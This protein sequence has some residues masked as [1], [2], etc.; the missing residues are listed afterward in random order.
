[1][2]KVTDLGFWMDSYIKA[3]LDSLCYNILDDWDGVVIVS[4][5]GMV[6]IGKSMLT[7][8]MAYYCLWKLHHNKLNWL[9]IKKQYIDCETTI[10]SGTELI[11]KG[12]S[13]MKNSVFKY[14]EAR[15]E[16][17][18]KKVLQEITITLM[19]YFSECGMYN[20]IVFLVIPEYFDLPKGLATN[21]S[22]FLINVYRK[23]DMIKLKDGTDIVKLQRGFFEFYSRDAKKKLYILGK[24]NFND[25]RASKYDFFGEFRP[26]WIV[27]KERYD[28]KK[29]LY[30]SRERKTNKITKDEERFPFALKAL[31]NHVSVRQASLELQSLGL[32]LGYRRI[33]QLIA[34]PIEN[35]LS[36]M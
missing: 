2:E 5:D 16:L 7:D 28:A 9:A 11:T 19:D 1:M 15:G 26:F 4:G 29:L 23:K 6:R 24:K 21:R 20:H 3:A 18:T 35:D 34:N 10:F 8:Q 12:K 30:L 22:E 32:E 36:E 27:N 14:D 13:Y 31:C 33:A 17:D 25:Y